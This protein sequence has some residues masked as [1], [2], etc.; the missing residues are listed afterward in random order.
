MPSMRKG[1]RDVRRP[2]KRP[3][4]YL[5]FEELLAIEE[6]ALTNKSVKGDLLEELAHRDTPRGRAMM[7]RVNQGYR[8]ADASGNSPPRPVTLSSASA[9]P[10]TSDQPNAE[11][12]RSQTRPSV[13][14]SPT[15]GNSVS[16][17]SSS[18]GSAPTLEQQFEALRATFTEEAEI[19]ARWG[20]T[21]ALPSAMQD[22]LLN[23]WRDRIGIVPDNFGRSIGRLDA[24]I[25]RL[26]DDRS[27]RRR[28]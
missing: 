22:A 17:P 1:N 15:A 3:Y 10:S 4:R 24:D 14:R 27:R 19:M 23:A 7:Q 26:N 25:K 18:E 8:M 11:H 13:P 21:S 16:S 2:G 5:E 6:Q 28:G 12:D 9:V 20:F